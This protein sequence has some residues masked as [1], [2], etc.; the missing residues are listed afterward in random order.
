[1][2]TMEAGRIAETAEEMEKNAQRSAER[3]YI[4]EI[5]RGLA[6]DKMDA[7]LLHK[8][9][10]LAPKALVYLHYSRSNPKGED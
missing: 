8:L 4:S 9:K 5:E 1:M 7:G 2:M 6:A 10:I 3:A